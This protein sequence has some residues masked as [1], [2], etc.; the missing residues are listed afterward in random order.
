MAEGKAPSAELE[1]VFG[2]MKNWLL[3]IY[4]Q[5]VGSS[6]DV[7][8]TDE[9]RGVMDRL[10]VEQPLPRTN[11]TDGIQGGITKGWA[12]PVRKYEFRYRL[13]N[14]DDVVASHTQ[15]LQPNPGYPGWLQPRMRDRADSAA[16]VDRIARQLDP[17]ELISRT[18]NLDSGPIIVGPD[19]LVESGNGRYLA[20]QRAAEAHPDRYKGYVDYLREN[21]EAFGLTADDLE[22]V[23]NPIL[24]RERITKVDRTAFAKEAN[25]ARSMR[26]GAVETA[27]A[28][29]GRISDE[30]LA[31]LD[32]TD[33]EGIDQALR[34]AKN[35]EIVR[36]FMDALPPEEAAALRGAG[37]ELAQA[38]LQRIKSALLAST[39]QGD[40]GTRLVAAMTEA[41]D[42]VV[43]NVENAIYG[44]LPQVARSEAATRSG[45][46]A[47]EL[48]I[49]DDIAAAVDVLARLKRE[50]PKVEEY[51]AQIGMFGAELTPEQLALLRFFETN[52]RSAKKIREFMQGYAAEVMAQ[53]APSQAALFGDF[54]RSS[55]A[56]LMG[57]VGKK[58][59]FD[60]LIIE[61][62]GGAPPGAPL[63][64]AAEGGY[65]HVDDAIR[66]AMEEAPKPISQTQAMR[67]RTDLTEQLLD[68]DAEI[69]TAFHQQ[70]DVGINRRLQELV[71][72]AENQRR[73]G[74]PDAELDRKLAT[75]SGWFD[76]P[77]ADF[78][79]QPAFRPPEEAGPLFGG[80]APT[81]TRGEAF[82]PPQVLDEPELPGMAP[83]PEQPRFAAPEPEG[84]ALPG[85]ELDA[86]E[87]GKFA[88]RWTGTPPRP[89]L[90]QTPNRGFYV[91]NAEGL[92]GRSFPPGTKG[93][94]AA[95]GYHAEQ[96]RIWDEANAE[97]GRVGFGTRPEEAR[98]AFLPGMEPAMGDKAKY[99]A[100]PVGE[101]LPP[102]PEGQMGLFDQPPAEPPT[103]PVEQPKFAAPKPGK[104]PDRG[105]GKWEPARLRMDHT[106]RI[107]RES[108]LRI[109]MDVWTAD[110][111]LGKLNTWGTE[112]AG[113]I[114]GDTVKEY[115]LRDLQVHVTKEWDEL[116]P[117]RKPKGQATLWQSN[118]AE[119]MG[120][121][122]E[123]PDNWREYMKAL[124]EPGASPGPLPPDLLDKSTQ[125]TR[126]A[127][128]KIEQGIL[129]EWDQWRAV[130]AD[131]EAKRALADWFTNEVRPSWYEQRAVA[132]EYATQQADFA[133]LDYAKRRNWD[134]WL[135]YV[136]PYHYWF[137]RAGKN[138][139]KRLARRP[140][141][142]G[143]Y[144]RVRDAM[145]LANERAGRRQRFEGKFRV[146]AA[147]LPGW[148]G[149]AL[150]VDPMKMIAPFANIFGTNW[151]DADDSATGLRKIYNTAQQFGLRPY[152]IWDYLY[153][154][155][156]LQK[157]GELIG[158]APGPAQQLLGPQYAG[159]FPYILPQTGLIKAGTAA[160]GQMGAD[161]VPPGG[162][163]IEA[164]LRRL[165]PGVP[166]GEIWDPYRVNRMLA[167]LAAERKHD[168]GYAQVVLR[169]QALVEAD[170]EQ[171]T[172]QVWSPDSALAQEVA[173]QWGWSPQQLQQAQEVLAEAM[174][175]AAL[176]RGVGTLGWL[177]GPQ[178]AVEPR[179][180]R[181]QLEMAEEA[182]ETVWT[183]EQPWGSREAYNQFKAEHPAMY[184]RA[185]QYATLPG[186]QD[187]NSMPPGAR[188]NWLILDHQKEMLHTDYD[189]AVDQVLRESIWNWDARND[190]EDQRRLALAELDEKYP[191]PEM[192]QDLPA[193][194]YGMNPAE[195]WD[196]TVEKELY[197]LQNDK[198]DPSD[199]EIEGEGVDWDS[200]YRDEERWRAGLPK[201]FSFGSAKGG[202]YDRL[203]PRTAMQ[204]FEQRYDSP[205][206]AAHK[207]YTR[208]IASPAWDA[209]N[210]EKEVEDQLF[211]GA[212]ELQSQ[213]FTLDQGGRRALL[214][215][216][217]VLGQF[218]DYK[219][220]YG[221]AYE[222]TV[223]KVESVPAV[224]LVPA[225]LANYQTKDW[226]EESLRAE[227]TG[228]VFPSLDE[229][230][231]LKRAWR[232]EESYDSSSSSGGG[233]GSL[234]SGGRSYGSGGGYSSSRWSPRRYTSGGSWQYPR[235]RPPAT[236][237]GGPFRG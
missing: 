188:A 116:R 132:F 65:T 156:A 111:R 54:Q 107:V 152:H 158:I 103:P 29:V 96:A 173:A 233:Y 193:I 48:S 166:A 221:S 226:T 149:D 203:D 207:V 22:G 183:P 236:F 104:P 140:G 25:E 20:I 106:G 5:I 214:R 210:K 89:T 127:V 19:G 182:G 61:G 172:G 52:K 59:G 67:I 94:R 42:P 56:D 10:L 163:N 70:N 139:A 36:A 87:P 71:N 74:V 92:G 133:L 143:S 232:G 235:W 150:Y 88:G 218:W 105:P 199:Y 128:D 165:L 145:K 135:S 23:N 91:T 57:V 80:E 1:G 178:M 39:Y 184:P 126:R 63:M 195:M 167:N 201:M 160:L 12:D 208:E 196:G 38:G 82:G 187:Y 51:L 129:G 198:P 213:Y 58:L 229:Q 142:L 62:P 147:W 171:Q 227:L 84:P 220:R 114:L 194:L 76:L 117:K 138:W 190:L 234:Y 237:R 211:P 4:Q 21:M 168:M 24:V 155:G 181:A 217:P 224:A 112:N 223:G 186:E 219:D 50:G 125:A 90:E 33:T 157:A 121:W 189:E 175:K 93:K 161:W 14:M 100:R 102:A 200:Y 206:E 222:R 180:E 27:A 35:R 170:K 108:N 141:M 78:A 162:V 86:E 16:Q 69:G 209:Y 43:K 118:E 79:K 230:Q 115:P 32:V 15:A 73:Y 34:A 231:D 122:R 159:N 41:V 205:L 191:M 60:D 75:L 28:D 130:P 37:G 144:I 30:M 47:A 177:T 164:P 18:T 123:D 77:E 131:Q 2:R 228:V 11:F 40:A 176:E 83:E 7:K 44:S 101:E 225:I 66:R 13:V 26:M 197:R 85:M 120:F 9:I 169:A 8:L 46:R 204:N 31:S 136:F 146:P 3:D 137:T 148:M 72:S 97:P 53:A 64:Q 113:V 216:N 192:T 215:A 45:A 98:D 49:S 179:G 110:G 68:L 17:E 99:A 174:Q 119:Q 124:N 55:K 153:Q 134:V 154:S 202:L 81:M 95:Q 6:L 185:T 212:R 109:G 151:D